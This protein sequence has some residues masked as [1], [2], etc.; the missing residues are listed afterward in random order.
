MT[1]CWGW[2]PAGL[3]SAV[4]GLGCR[5]LH[6]VDH[7]QGS[8]EL[9]SQVVS[10]LDGPVP[11]VVGLHGIRLGCGELLLEIAGSGLG[12][13]GLQVSDLLLV[14]GDHRV[15][16]LEGA[17]VQ[18]VGLLEVGGDVGRRLE[19]RGHAAGQRKL[20]GVLRSALGG[21]D[22]ERARGLPVVGHDIVD[23]TF[24]DAGQRDVGRRLRHGRGRGEGDDGREGQKEEAGEGDDH[25]WVPCLS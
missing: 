16:G 12:Q 18:P 5:R 4:S 13:Q 3:G 6:G 9:R 25:R 23:H 2:K 1:S 17:F 19:A 14:R 15:A 20:P 11:L 21:L 10:L 8:L 7:R 22:T 24:P